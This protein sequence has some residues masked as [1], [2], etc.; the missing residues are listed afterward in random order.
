MGEGT[1]SQYGYGIQAASEFHGQYLMPSELL[2]IR[3]C[4]FEYSKEAGAVA[5]LGAGAQVVRLQGNSCERSRGR[6]QDW[7]GG[8][9]RSDRVSASLTGSSGA[10][11]PTEGTSIWAQMTRP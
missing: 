8:Q 2:A 4:Q 1:E 9:C 5:E 11:M 3:L 6:K 10:K 7:T